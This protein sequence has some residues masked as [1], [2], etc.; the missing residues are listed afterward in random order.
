[1][2]NKEK[3]SAHIAKNGLRHTF[4]RDQMLQHIETINGH[5]TASGLI[6]T[7]GKKENVSNASIYRNLNLFVEAGIVTEHRFPVPETVY[8]LTSRAITHCHRICTICGE[9]KEFR[10][11]QV[12]SALKHH[13][14][15]AFKM[16]NSNVYVYGIC[17]K[18]LTNN[19][20]KQ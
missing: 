1:M 19:S 12:S 15:R 20:T 7:F 6:E 2:T 16:H 11:A 8:E 14:F 4:E 13:R 9:V 5:F 17:K 18:C 3:L 10:D